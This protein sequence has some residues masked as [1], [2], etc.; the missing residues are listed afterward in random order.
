[1]TSEIR[2]ITRLYE[3]MQ[4]HSSCRAVSVYFR[5]LVSRVN[6]I[7]TDNAK[8]KAQMD[9]KLSTKQK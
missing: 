8:G 9:K 5:E 6:K 1:M 2:V 4:I 7:R 3:D